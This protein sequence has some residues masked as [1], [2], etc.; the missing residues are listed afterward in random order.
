MDW[1]KKIES[2]LVVSLQAPNI[3]KDVSC[4]FRRPQR[5]QKDLKRNIRRFMCFFSGPTQIKIEGCWAGS[6]YLTYFD[7]F[8]HNV[9]RDSERKINN[10]SDNYCLVKRLFLLLLGRP[11][12]IHQLYLCLL[13]QKNSQYNLSQAPLEKSKYSF[14]QIVIILP[15]L[16][17][18]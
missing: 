6:T 3:S 9:I 18:T 12:K 16:P 15:F 2:F 13:D 5:Y 7:S 14:F 11:N 4:V 17:E 8:I 1:L 10:V